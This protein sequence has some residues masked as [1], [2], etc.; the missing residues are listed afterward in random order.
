MRTEVPVNGVSV[1][2]I[3]RSIFMAERVGFEPKALL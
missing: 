2:L 1:N 3:C